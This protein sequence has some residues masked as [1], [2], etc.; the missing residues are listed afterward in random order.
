MKRRY[1]TSSWIRRRSRFLIAAI[2]TL[3]AVITFY[4]TIV[5]LGGTLVC[6]VNGCDRVLFS[7]Y[8]S[9]FGFPLT[10]FGFF[11]YF[12]MVV[13]AVAPLLV[14]S[15]ENKK[16]RSKLEQWTGLLLF[17]GGT[18]ML[19]FSC[20]LMYLLAFEIQTICI[21]CVASALFSASLFILTLMGRDWQDIGQLFFTVIVVSI[22]VLVGILGVYANANKTSTALQDDYAIKTNSNV[23]QIALAQHL[24]KIGAKM[25][26]SFTCAY[27]RNQKHLFGKEAASQLNYIECHPNGKNAQPDLCQAARIQAFPTWEIKGRFYQG[28]QSLEKL[29]ELSSFQK[30]HNFQ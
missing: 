26:G 7:P 14:N 19:V 1:F 23:F 10:L 12:R 24:K 21:Y 5:K 22:I 27:C 28:E 9:I 20:Y 2:A 8:A 17:V 15:A 18:A 11:A 13:F 30:A 16:L 3:G 25:Y 4:L 29:A 6:P